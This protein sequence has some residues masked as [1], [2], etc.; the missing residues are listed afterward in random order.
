MFLLQYEVCT[1][2]LIV[3]HNIKQMSPA[4]LLYLATWSLTVTTYLVSWWLPYQMSGNR[5]LS[6]EVIYFNI[7]GAQWA[8]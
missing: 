4:P 7:P 2:Q 3:E 1:M 6:V 8:Q 5:R